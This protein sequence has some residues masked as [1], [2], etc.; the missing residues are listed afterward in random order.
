M[1]PCQVR[2]I[3]AAGATAS[4]SRAASIRI[5]A[6]KPRTKLRVEARRMRSNSSSQRERCV[7]GRFRRK[8]STGL[9]PATALVLL[10]CYCN[11]W[12]CRGRVRERM[13]SHQLGCCRVVRRYKKRRRS[14]G[15]GGGRGACSAAVEGS[16][17]MRDR[18]TQ[19]SLSQKS[20]WPR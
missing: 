11:L 3:P 5:A 19:L 4:S 15:G 7:P 18:T 14:E 6:A 10:F 20:R 17:G 8:H 2:L 16:T 1:K 9:E 12:S 13:G